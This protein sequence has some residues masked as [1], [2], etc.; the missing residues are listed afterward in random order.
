MTYQVSQDLVFLYLSLRLS[1]FPSNLLLSGFSST[2][3]P[4]VLSQQLCTASF[5]FLE[6]FSPSILTLLLGLWLNITLSRTA[7]QAT[8]SE[9]SHVLYPSYSP[10]LLYFLNLLS[11]YFVFWLFILSIIW[12]L[13]LNTTEI[14]TEIFVWLPLL[15]QQ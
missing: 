8:L 1:S 5:F 3:R 7:S 4:G 2:Y 13:S 6:Y 14:S 15:P 11:K 12:L 9:I 10:P